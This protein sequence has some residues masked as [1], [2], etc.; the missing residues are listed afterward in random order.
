VPPHAAGYYIELTALSVAVALL[1]AAINTHAELSP[2]LSPRF[3]TASITTLTPHPSAS[4]YSY[5]IVPTAAA[6]I[7]NTAKA[8]SVH[9]LHVV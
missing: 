7:F 9:E 6:G 5:M 2:V 4:S 8:L 1:K 3:S